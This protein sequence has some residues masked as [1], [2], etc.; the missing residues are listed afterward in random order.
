MTGIGY[1]S[2]LHIIMTGLASHYI[3]ELP[4][5]VTWFS[6]SGIELKGSAILRHPEFNP[7][8]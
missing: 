4:S 7:I 6:V 5:S 1:E 8:N 2:V 3:L